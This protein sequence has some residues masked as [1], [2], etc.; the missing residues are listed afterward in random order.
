LEEDEAMANIR[1][2]IEGWLEAAQDKYDR[3]PL[4]GTLELVTV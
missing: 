4:E 3:A 1:E 2:A